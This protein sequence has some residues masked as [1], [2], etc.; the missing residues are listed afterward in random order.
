MLGDVLFGAS[1]DHWFVSVA[2]SFRAQ[3]T[4]GLGMPV[5]FLMFTVPAILF[6]PIGEEL[7]FRGYLQR[8]LETRF[9]Q[10]SSTVIEGLWFAGAHLVHHGIFMTATGVSVR[11][12][13]GG[14]WFLLMF[15]LSC[16][17][18]WL[19]KRHDSILPAI[20]AHAA[21]NFTMNCFIFGLLWKPAG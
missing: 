12:V 1:A 6:S 14:L 5:I 17:F 16:M 7:F 19:R 15:A 21:F 10:R 9:S 13:S 18:A 3:P 11:P 20:V 2:N 4:P 8:M